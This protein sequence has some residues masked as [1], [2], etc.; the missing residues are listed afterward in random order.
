MP[1]GLNYREPWKLRVLVVEDNTADFHW[2]KK[3]LEGMEEYEATIV[4]ASHIATANAIIKEQ[5]F[6]LALVDY[7]LPDGKGDEVLV[8]LGNSV[9]HCAAIM[10]SGYKMSEVSLFGL[11]G[12]AV[13]ALSKDDLNP[14]LLETTIRFALSNHTN[15][16]KREPDVVGRL[17]VE[18]RCPTIQWRG[19]T[20]VL[21]SGAS[22]DKETGKAVDI[23]Q[24][25]Q[26]QAAA[27]KN[28]NAVAFGFVSG[29]WV[30]VA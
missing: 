15:A 22:V 5:Q 7:Q 3:T 17:G 27:R 9:D 23:T 8:G 11:R 14:G 19:R 20:L 28:P 30:P 21:L 16:N 10:L 12:G 4:H 26:L 29:R 13:A 18:A 24:H 25:E 2:I 6:D 1:V